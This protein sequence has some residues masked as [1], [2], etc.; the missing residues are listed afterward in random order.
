M[1]RGLKFTIL[2]FGQLWVW[3]W[4]SN[5][6]TVTNCQMRILFCT[7]LHHFKSRLCTALALNH[8]IKL[9]HTPYIYTLMM[10]LS[11]VCIAQ[12][13]LEI[14]KWLRIF[15]LYA[16]TYQCSTEC[17]CTWDQV[18]LYVYVYYIEQLLCGFEV[19]CSASVPCIA[20]CVQVSSLQGGRR[21]PWWPRV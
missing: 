18:Y 20:L 11:G 6:D 7:K 16:H 14:V 1:L 8:E 9:F 2:W 21:M 10:W 4:R 5:H 17:R 12:F 19:I 3:N 15:R 13:G